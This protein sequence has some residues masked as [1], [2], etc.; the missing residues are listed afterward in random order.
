MDA[1]QLGET[2]EAFPHS[3]KSRIEGEVRHY[4]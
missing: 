2:G 4:S 1:G 3:K